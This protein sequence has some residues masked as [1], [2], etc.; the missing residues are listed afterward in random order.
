MKYH[1]LDLGVNKLFEE[2]MMHVYRDLWWDDLADMRSVRNL[3][4]SLKQ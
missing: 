4:K 2:L 3:V 1:R